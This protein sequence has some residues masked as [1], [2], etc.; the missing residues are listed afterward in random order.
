MLDVS[1]PASSS[2][3]DLRQAFDATGTILI[4]EA[5][6]CAPWDEYIYD[7]RQERDALARHLRHVPSARVIEVPYSEG[8]GWREAGVF[9][10]LVVEK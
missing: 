3:A 10:V 8:T 6:E 9:S 2:L 1:L 4:A 7:R 5:T